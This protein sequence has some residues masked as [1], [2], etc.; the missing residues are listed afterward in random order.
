MAKA[1]QT[2]SVQPHR[3]L[4][5]VT[6]A[7]MTVTGDVRMPLTVLERRMTLV[8]L[9]DGRLVVYSAIALEEASMRELEEFG[10]PAFLVVP[11]H[12]HRNDALIWKLR[13]PS[14][15][16]VSPVG[17]RSQVSEVVSVDTCAPDFGDESVR[18]VEV[19]GTAGREGALEVREQ[20]GMTLVLNDI[21]G[22]LPRSAG[23]V[24]RAMGFAAERPR[25]PRMVKR[26]LV[27]D[28]AALR[29]Q[30]EYW[31]QQPVDRI[32]VSHGRP[33]LVDARAVLRE[34][35]TTV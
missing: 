13:Y 4:E 6:P 10:R 20:G 33:I 27:K 31:S 5:R 23:W 35:A 1:L 14:L 18:F 22:N 17:A 24:L 12:L 26:V 19:P 30:L 28:R 2:W 16:V 21:V 3:P 7:I 9:G 15:V 11:S 29:S 25:V 34:L 8:R 32:L